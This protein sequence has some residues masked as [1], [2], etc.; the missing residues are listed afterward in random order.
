MSTLAWTCC[1]RQGAHANASESVAPDF[2]YSDAVR[3]ILRFQTRCVAF[4]GPLLIFLRA[5]HERA[6]LAEGMT[7]R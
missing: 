6:L 1:Y 7:G 4:G 5:H 2:V 3:R